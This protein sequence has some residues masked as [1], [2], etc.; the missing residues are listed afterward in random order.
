MRVD[1]SSAFAKQQWARR[2]LIVKGETSM[3][4]AIWIL[5]I[6]A[7]GGCEHCGADDEY[8]V[9]GPN[10][11]EGQEDDICTSKGFEYASDGG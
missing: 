7:A 6:L 11:Y 8:C 10:S 5:L 4:K 9:D 2:A 3:K 1:A